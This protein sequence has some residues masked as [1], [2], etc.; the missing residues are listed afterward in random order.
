MSYLTGS[1]MLASAKSS[2]LHIFKVPRTQQQ[3]PY[4]P[5]LF[6]AYDPPP[7][8]LFHRLLA[9]PHE[10]HLKESYSD[11]VTNLVSKTTENLVSTV[12][13][14]LIAKC[15]K[16]LVRLESAGVKMSLVDKG[17]P[18]VFRVICEEETYG[19]HLMFPELE[20]PPDFQ[21]SAQ[22]LSCKRNI[23]KLVRPEEEETNVVDSL[24]S[25]KLDLAHLVLKRRRG[26]PFSA[27]ELSSMSLFWTHLKNVGTV[28]TEILAYSKQS[29]AI[30]LRNKREEEIDGEIE[31]NYH[32][33]RF[34]KISTQRM[35]VWLQ[36]QMLMDHWFLTDVDFADEQIK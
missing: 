28:R 8:P 10:A 36:S 35:S 34:T 14:S 20:P 33:L 26:E 7:T 25:L 13:H 18:E 12:F 24:A 15:D 29:K 3:L 6:G 30:V 19:T 22:S 2:A 4:L 32:V 11:F 17:S 16:S 23:M 5:F 27:N 31:P 21:Y 1:I 9:S